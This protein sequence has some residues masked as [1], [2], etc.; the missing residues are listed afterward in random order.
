MHYDVVL[1]LPLKVF[2]LYNTN[3]SRLRAEEDKRLLILFASA[4]DGESIR[5]TMDRLEQEND[6]PIRVIPPQFVKPE[7]GALDKLK[8]LSNQ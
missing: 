1:D 5:K 2:S 7:E 3:I 6:E 8:A 4:N